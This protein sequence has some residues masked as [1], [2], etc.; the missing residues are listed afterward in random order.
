MKT[1][2]RMSRRW[3]AAAL[4]ALWLAPA[5]A[6]EVHSLTLPEA[7]ER[8]LAGN[9][10]LVIA[11]LDQQKA[12]QGIRVAKDPFFPKIFLGSGLAATYGFPLSVEGSAPSIVEVQGIAALI[13][14]P[15]R[16]RL[17]Q[18][19]QEAKGAA[20]DRRQQRDRI[21]LRT[22]EL[23]L[24]ADRAAKSAKVARA[25][26]AGLVRVAETMRLR[27]EAG[28]ELPIEQKRAALDVALARQ[29]AEA[30]AADL[31][32]AEERLATVLGYE[33]G[34]RVQAVP[35]E[36]PGLA[37]PETAEATVSRA[38]EDN[39]E[40]RRLQSSLVAKGFAVKAERA[41]GRPR[42]NVVGKYGL[43]ARYNNYDEFFNKF[44]R[45]NALL[46]IQFEVPLYPG[47]GAKAKA[48]QAELD[49]QRLR[50]ELRS[51]RGR[52]TLEA[53]HAYQEAR[54]AETALEVAR[55]DLE[56]AR[57]QLGVLLAKMEEGRAP[58]KE[59]EAAR[60]IEN[61]KWISFYNAHTGLE[62]A[63]YRL[64]A[65]TGGLLAAVRQGGH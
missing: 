47:P 30:F 44:Q 14:R 50:A 10:D 41:A 15:A 22:V 38:L 49:V 65:K 40:V 56:V 61:E 8:A 55:L 60:Y 35:D 42:L 45:H 29:R 23:F 63:R 25:Q 31:E 53:R 62:L 16:Y 32:Y 4:L 26:V 27:T 37:L 13:N 2:E 34:D 28:R 33:P 64:L 20:L 21:A 17:H 19:E 12:E 57:D 54:K 1:N 36:R 11:R 7:V 43:F 46:G 24:D 48:A 52:I 6:A 9:P 59:V 58:L 3:C 39:L 5:A 18:A 51:Q